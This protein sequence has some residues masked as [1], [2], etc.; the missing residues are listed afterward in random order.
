M[1][2]SRNHQRCFS[3]TDSCIDLMGLSP[4]DLCAQNKHKSHLLQNPNNPPKGSSL[5]QHSDIFISKCRYVAHAPHI[6]EKMQSLFAMIFSIFNCLKQPFS[7]F[8]KDTPTSF[9]LMSF[10]FFSHVKLCRV[11]TIENTSC[12][13]VYIG[14]EAAIE[15]TLQSPLRIEPSHY[16][17]VEPKDVKT[18]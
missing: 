10:I 4:R 11:Y 9:F 13:H 15:F 14:W 18:K 16:F 5:L 3:L 6:L 17:G 7:V 2:S 1:K 8:Y 12:I